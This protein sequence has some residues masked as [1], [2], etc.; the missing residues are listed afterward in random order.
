MWAIQSRWVTAC[1]SS[2]IDYGPGYRLYYGNDGRTLILLLCG[3]DKRSQKK[4]ILKAQEYWRDYM[5]R[6]KLSLRESG[7]EKKNKR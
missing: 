6:K 5:T 1:M 3:G 7:H 4:D 2:R